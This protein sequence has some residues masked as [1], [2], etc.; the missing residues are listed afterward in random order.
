MSETKKNNFE[1]LETSEGVVV[2]L[3][4]NVRGGDDALV[5]MEIVASA[6]ENGAKTVI[7]DLSAVKTINSSGLGMLVKAYTEAKSSGAT[8]VLKN[9]PEKAKK[10][11]ETTRLDKVFRIIG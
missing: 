7:A 9:V 8:F 10:L 6:I 3:S 2:K 5:F 4:E 1:T 11:L